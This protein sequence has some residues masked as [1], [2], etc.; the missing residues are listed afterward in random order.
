M[1]LGEN[2][3]LEIR[4][5]SANGQGTVQFRVQPTVRAE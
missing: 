3:P 4:Y 1:S 5:S 2:A